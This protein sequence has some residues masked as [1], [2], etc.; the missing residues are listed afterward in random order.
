[1]MLLPTYVPRPPRSHAVDSTDR[2]T[3]V[4]SDQGESKICCCVLN[5]D[6]TI[7]M[8]GTRKTSERVIITA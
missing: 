7:Q 8:S 6:I 5:A 1:M 4:G 3:D 2:S